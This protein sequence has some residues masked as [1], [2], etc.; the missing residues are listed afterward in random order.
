[1]QKLKSRGKTIVKYHLTINIIK[2]IKI[3][4]DRSFRELFQRVGFEWLASERTLTIE[5]LLSKADTYYKVKKQN[6][7]WE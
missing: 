5:G 2:T 7:T 1:M 3:A 6:N 4:K